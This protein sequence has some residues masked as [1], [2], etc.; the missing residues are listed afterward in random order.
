[1]PNSDQIA[2][3]NGDMAANW[4][5][6]NALME[7][8]LAP[9]G[10]RIL[11][12]LSLPATARALDVGCGCGHPT[13]SLA[14][15]IGSDG[16]VIGIDVSAPMLALAEEL[17]VQDTADRAEV[18][19]LEADAQTHAFKPESLEIV[20]SRFGVMF[21]DDPVAA[22]RNI[23]NALTVNGQLAFCCWQPRA[24]NPFMTMPAMAA[25]ELLP[26]PPE[27]PPR[28]P[29]PFAFAEADYVEAILIEA[30]FKD[31]AI[32]PISHPLVFGSGLS[33]EEIVERLVNIGPIAQMVREAPEGLQQ[34][35]REKV[36][37]AVSPFYEQSSGMTLDGQFWQVTARG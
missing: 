9:V 30:G 21:F 37:A 22:F 12:T 18:T 27:M 25:L 10:E 4:V 7:A 23:H 6:H 28:T 26:A 33:V 1:M 8:M 16:S 34:P 13:L 2:C 19:F 14:Q 36:I 17:A 24:V 20:F 3:W 31:I 29:G 32:T 35:V 5:E 15:R 11:D